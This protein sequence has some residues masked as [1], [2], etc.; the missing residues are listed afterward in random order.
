MCESEMKEVAGCM[1]MELVG[2]HV[3]NVFAGKLLII[4]RN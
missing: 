1:G 4:S 2:L 3:K